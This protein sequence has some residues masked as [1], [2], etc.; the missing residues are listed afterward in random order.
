MTVDAPGNIYIT[1]ATTDAIPLVN[2]VQ[3]ALGGG[4][5]GVSANRFDPQFGFEYL[6][7]SDLG[8][9]NSCR[10]TSGPDRQVTRESFCQVSVTDSDLR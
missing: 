2:A 8:H 6:S 10:R 1:G 4:N 9:G 3:P 7:L 5:C